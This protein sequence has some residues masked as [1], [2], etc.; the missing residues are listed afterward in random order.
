MA[1]GRDTQVTAHRIVEFGVVLHADLVGFTPLAQATT[2]AGPAQVE[3][4]H[5]LLD[6]SFTQMA[7]AVECHGGQVVALAGDALTATFVGASMSEWS[8]SECRQRAQR[9]AADVLRVIATLDASGVSG[10][11]LRRDGAAGGVLAGGGPGGAGPTGADSR[12]ADSRGADSRGAVMAVGGFRVGL[13]DGEIHRLRIQTYAADSRVAGTTYDVVTGPAVARAV[14]AQ[15]RAAVGKTSVTWSADGRPRSLQRRAA[16]PVGVDEGSAPTWLHADPATRPV[17]RAT[18]P[19]AAARGGGGAPEHRVV[20][21][22]FVRFGSTHIGMPTESM[23]LGGMHVG[24]EPVGAEGGVLVDFIA[25]A[26]AVVAGHGGD[27]RQIDGSGSAYQLVLGFG[28]PTST[29]DDVN[30]A[31]G[32]CLRLL[33]LAEA[34]GLVASAGVATGEVFCADLGGHGEYVV[35][36][37]SVNHAARLAAHADPTVLLVDDTTA[38]RC[39]SHFAIAPA[40]TIPLKGRTD[41]IAHTVAGLRGDR[42]AATAPRVARFTVGRDRELT[43]LLHHA[44]RAAQG[45]GSTVVLTGGAGLGKTHLLDVFA[46]QVPA[47]VVRGQAGDVGDLR[48]YLPWHPVIHDLATEALRVTKGSGAPS[49]DGGAEDQ[50]IAAAQD[51]EAALP[52]ADA[53]FLPLLAEAAGLSIDPTPTVSALTPLDRAATTRRL[54]SDLLARSITPARADRRGEDLREPLVVLLDDAER[55]DELSI[56]LTR[57]VV[58]RAAGLPVLLVLTARELPSWSSETIP[59]RVV[60]EIVLE[61]LSP[62]C[63]LRLTRRLLGARHPR[64]E[65]VAARSGGNPLFVRH[66]AAWVRHEREARRLPPDLRRLVI[67]RV[68]R[69]PDATRCVLQAAAVIGSAERR[70]LLRRCVVAL[71]GHDSGRAEVDAELERLCA[72]GLLARAGAEMHAGYVFGDPLVRDVVYAGMSVV[73]RARLHEIVGH[74]LERALRGD[75]SVTPDMLAVHFGRSTDAAKRLQ[76]TRAA[77]ARAEAT[78][79]TTHAI[80]HLGHLLEIDDE[81]A[82]ADL[83]V[84]RGRMLALAGRTAEAEADLRAARDHAVGADPDAVTARADRELGVTLLSTERFEEGLALLAQAA[85]QLERAG[86]VEGCLTALDRLAFGRLQHGALEEAAQAAH[87]QDAL[88]RADG[89]PGRRAA[90]TQNLALLAWRRGGNQEALQLMRRARAWAGQAGDRRLLVHTA[91]DL[92]GMLAGT[93]AVE[94]AAA[95]LTEALEAAR[96]I[97]YR[98]ATAGMLGNLAELHRHLRSTRSAAQIALAGLEDALDL[99]DAPAVAQLTVNLALCLRDDGRP[100][101]A[102][103]LAEAACIAGALDQIEAAADALGDGPPDAAPSAG[104]PPSGA[105]GPLPRPPGLLPATPQRVDAAFAR[106]H[107]LAARHAPALHTPD[108]A[109]CRP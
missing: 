30:A 85:V 15:A 106:A 70:A 79:A 59:H 37:D 105:A 25:Q 51:L 46:A 69:L 55:F 104:S 5:A 52:T 20:S 73:T 21:T 36:G 45:V 63:S 89:H 103:L 14:R 32:C 95:H 12:V 93:G 54:V 91:N 27:L 98:G 84:R 31:V 7:A 100:E 50:G 11:D 48:A 2:A 58:A 75:P 29:P 78:Y 57:E 102:T 24:A 43:A 90:A 94:P 1:P 101:A 47:R 44:R 96:Q 88:A 49:S 76:W 99:A 77:A 81:P 26:V 56:A 83:L 34:H 16:E 19:E 86:D 72:L 97:G 13:G 39:S 35:V 3:A 6:A 109:P 23:R 60:H 18:R 42:R 82:R 65:E 67:A 17:R 8:M 10:S 22:G 87:H 108:L 62:A 38:R 107:H 66:L 92:A 4:L 61:P 9:A 53:A 64:V 33:R 28:A 41:E 71:A 74:A 40:G 68:D 80:D